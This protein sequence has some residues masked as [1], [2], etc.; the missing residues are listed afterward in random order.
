MSASRSAS[1]SSKNRT[2]YRLLGG[3]DL[4]C[5]PRDR[6]GLWRLGDLRPMKSWVRE[7]LDRPRDEPPP[8]L[9]Q[10]HGPRPVFAATYPKYHGPLRPVAMPYRM[11]EIGAAVDLDLMSRADLQQLAK[12]VSHYDPNVP[13]GAK[14]ARCQDQ[15]MVELFP[16]H[17]AH[18]QRAAEILRDLARIKLRPASDANFVQFNRLY[19][20]LPPYAKWRRWWPVELAVMPGQ[21]FR[22]HP[23]RA[24]KQERKIP[25]VGQ[26]QEVTP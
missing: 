8:M 25:T 5:D 9:D 3:C 19:R 12:Q 2:G 6:H 14:T 15:W 26:N 11:R 17:P 24:K 7:I 22:K 4:V 21:K 10:R 1:V 18:F 13:M 16:T 20:L 23:P